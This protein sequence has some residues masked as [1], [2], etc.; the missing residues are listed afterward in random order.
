MKH[1]SRPSLTEVR[2]AVRLLV[3]GHI[4][5]LCVAR[6]GGEFDVTRSLE[7]LVKLPMISDAQDQSHNLTHTGSR[8]SLQ[9]ILN[10]RGLTI[11]WD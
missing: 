10:G 3:G 11:T 4:W 1:G 7:D 6:G 9:A 8:L 5:Q 2:F